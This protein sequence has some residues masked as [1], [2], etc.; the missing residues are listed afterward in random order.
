MRVLRLALFCLMLSPIPAGAG[1]G[2]ENILPGLASSDPAAHQSFFERAHSVPYG[3]G[4]FWRVEKAGMAPSYVFGTFHVPE[5]TRLGLTDVVLDALRRTSRIV[6]EVDSTA[7]RAQTRALNRPSRPLEQNLGA[8]MMR[9]LTSL[10]PPESKIDPASTVSPLEVLARIEVMPCMFEGGPAM[11]SLIQDW[12]RS[13]GLPVVGLEAPGDAVAMFSA[14]NER[15][16][17]ELVRETI[18]QYKAVAR[19]DAYQTVLALYLADETQAV[20]D[21]SRLMSERAGSDPG[22]ARAMADL[23]TEHLMTQRNLAWRKEINSQLEKGGTFI[24]VGAGHL[25]GENG[26][27]AL[28]ERAGYKVTR[29]DPGPPSPAGAAG[30]LTSATKD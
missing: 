29:L 10:L 20:L 1:C 3:S 19:D 27:L 9:E 6:V 24:A 18:R 25:P 21:L 8:D 5:A 16:A 28:I 15:Q 2:G 13:K 4:R 26:I 14:M 7:A 11:D 22:H 12:A 17:W 23:L 30:L